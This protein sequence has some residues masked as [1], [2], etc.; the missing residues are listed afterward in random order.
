[1]KVLRNVTSALSC[2]ASATWILSS[3]KFAH[4]P[5]LLFNRYSISGVKYSIKPREN[6]P[7]LISNGEMV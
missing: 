6:S 4:K 7:Y 1:M 3:D 5:Y 2:L